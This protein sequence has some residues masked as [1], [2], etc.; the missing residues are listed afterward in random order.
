MTSKQKEFLLLRA[1]GISFDKIA[2]Q[3]NV[4]KP[5]LIQWSK[6]FADDIN[7]MQFQSLADL[8]QQYRF[9]KRDKYEQLLKHLNKI[10]EAIEMIDLQNTSLKE[11]MTVRNSISIQLSNIERSTSFINTAL[12]KKTIMGD[13]E[14]LSI[15]LDEIE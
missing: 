6:L 11:L 5:T 2:Q 14:Q 7:D 12:Y 9:S 3:I 13:K 8:K 10:D 1:D 15:R 4:S